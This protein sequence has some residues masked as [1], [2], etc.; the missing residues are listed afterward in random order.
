MIESPRFFRKLERRLKKAQRSLSRKAKGSANRSKARLK[1]AK[2]HEKIKDSRSDWVDKQVKA[3]VSENQ[4]F[5][6]EDLSVKGL[7]QGRAAK[8]IHDAAFGMF[9]TRLES[10]AARAGRTFARV[11]RFFPSTRLC[12]DCGALTGPTGLEGLRM[13]EWACGC[14]AVHDR[15][16]NAEIN[17]RREGKR[18]VAAGQADTR[19]ASGQDVRP[20]KPGRPGNPRKGE[21][22]EPI[23]SGA[24]PMALK[25]SISAL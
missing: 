2:I 14:G 17:I 24:M 8:S 4:A 15:D 19:N 13:R 6:V 1:V 10:K 18:L 25:P 22:E 9:L 5:Y 11:N 16:R 23:R 7:A 3:L 21:N 20:G 12:S